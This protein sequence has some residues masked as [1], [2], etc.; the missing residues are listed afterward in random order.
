MADQTQKELHDNTRAFRDNYITG[1]LTNEVHLGAAKGLAALAAFIGDHHSKLVQ[2]I[3]RCMALPPQTTPYQLDVGEETGLE[4]YWA[5]EWI[6]SPPPWFDQWKK[7]HPVYLIAL[8]IL[9]EALKLVEHLKMS[10][11]Q[12][13]WLMSMADTPGLV[14][15]DGT[16]FGFAKYEQLDRKWMIAALNYVLN[17]VHNDIHPFVGANLTAEPMSS[18]QGKVEVVLGIVGDWGG[19]AYKEGPNKDI[20]SPAERVKSD[21]E[22]HSLDYLV[23]LGD[24]YYAGTDGHSRLGPDSANEEQDNLVDMWPKGCADRSFTL[25]S[26]H[27]M[28]GAADGYFKVALEKPGLFPKQHG[29][30]YFAL[31]Y[32]FGKDKD[33]SW[34]VLGLDSAYFSDQQNGHKMYMDGAIGVDRGSAKQTEQMTQI[35]ALAEQHPGPIMVMTHHNPW[36]TITRKVNRLFLQVETALKRQPTLWY[37][38]HVHNGIVYPDV[39][40]GPET[41]GRCCGHGAVPFGNA[42]GIAEQTKT[43]YYSHTHDDAFDAGNPRVYNGYALV[44]FQ[45][46]GSV[47]ETF[48]EIRKPGEDGVRVWSAQWKPPGAG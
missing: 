40:D 5:S 1:N 24:T 17:V 20:P 43:L 19:G 6:A 15:N 26:N 45:G 46:D 22:R 39:V 21:L 48:Y 25:N 4:L 3:T 37:W 7:E 32:K 11:A 23:H 10:K 35:R 31:E 18:Q 13:D 30:S 33:Q 14:G 2:E 27:E 16:I 12:Y 44:A 47:I 41:L 8:D 34:L 9:A 28:Y 36:D 42:W 29:A 38:G